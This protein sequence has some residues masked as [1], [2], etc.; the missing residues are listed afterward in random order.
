MDT[1]GVAL[2]LAILI[3]IICAAALIKR[4][5]EDREFYERLKRKAKARAVICKKIYLSGCGK[6]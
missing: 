1:L 6:R 5:R 2:G 3:L 4:I